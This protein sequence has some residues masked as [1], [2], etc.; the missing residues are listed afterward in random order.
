MIF[1][2]PNEYGTRCNIAM[3]GESVRN[4]DKV[5]RPAPVIEQDIAKS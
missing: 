4:V 3:L 1:W 5:L 2:D